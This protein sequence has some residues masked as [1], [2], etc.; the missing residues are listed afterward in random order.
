MLLTN[1]TTNLIAHNYILQCV[2]SDNKFVQIFF[3]VIL[4]IPLILPR[5]VGPRSLKCFI[6]CPIYKKFAD[7]CC[8]GL[9]ESQQCGTSTFTIIWFAKSTEHPAAHLAPSLS[10]VKYHATVNLALVLKNHASV[11]ARDVMRY[12]ELGQS[13]LVGN[14]VAGLETMRMVVTWSRMRYHWFVSLSTC[15]PVDL[16]AALS[17]CCKWIDLQQWN[18]N[19]WIIFCLKNLI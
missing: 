10:P 8:R 19:P 14:D 9:R 18:V 12:S 6:F 15:L 16:L 17:C 13:W 5:S 4:Y 3:V 1:Y 7:V 2:Y 11:N